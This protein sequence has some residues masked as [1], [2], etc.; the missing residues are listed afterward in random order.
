MNIL[1]DGVSE[2][3]ISMNEPYLIANSKHLETGGID[4]L[5]MIDIPDSISPPIPNNGNNTDEIK[6]VNNEKIEKDNEMDQISKDRDSIGSESI[7]STFFVYNS[8]Y[9]S[10]NAITKAC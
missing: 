6:S 8:L 3:Y 7:N 10:S 1:D 4:Y 5:T 2:H 9:Q